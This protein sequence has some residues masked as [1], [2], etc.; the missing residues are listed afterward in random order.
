MFPPI[1]KDFF[2]RFLVATS[3]DLRLKRPA[4]VSYEFGG[5]K[6]EGGKKFMENFLRGKWCNEKRAP[7]CL[8]YIGDDILPQLYRDYNKP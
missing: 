7:G 2:F 1:F 5:W 4:Q 6:I 8:G 3:S